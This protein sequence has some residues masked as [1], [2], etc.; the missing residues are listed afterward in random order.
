MRGRDDGLRWC[1]RFCRTRREL[2]D[3]PRWRHRGVVGRDSAIA[4]RSDLAR[5]PLVGRRSHR[6]QVGAGSDDRPVRGARRSRGV[7][8]MLTLWAGAIAAGVAL[9]VSYTLSPMGVWFVVASVAIVWA[10]GRHLPLREQRW[11]RGL[12]VAAL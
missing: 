6:G 11:I 3:G 7:P 9:G 4:R 10:G 8:A 2:P 12:L 1:R 5:P